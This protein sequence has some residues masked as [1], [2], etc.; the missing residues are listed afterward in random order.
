M[1]NHNGREKKWL[2]HFEPFSFHTLEKSFLWANLWSDGEGEELKSFKF[3]RDM[4]ALRRSP[5]GAKEDGNWFWFLDESIL[6]LCW[7]ANHLLQFGQVCP[8]SPQWWQKCCFFCWDFLLFSLFVLDFLASFFSTLGGAPRIDLPLS[9]FSLANYFLASS[10]LELTLLVGETK[11]VVL[12]KA[13]L[14]EEK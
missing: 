7:V 14:G 6:L 2:N 5:R 1:H 10:F 11:I 9:K 4:T 3:E 13:I 8:K 12:D